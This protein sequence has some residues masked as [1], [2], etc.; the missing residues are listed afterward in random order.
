[1]KKKIG[2]IIF[3]ILIL[4]IIGIEVFVKKSGNDTYF[5]GI[6]TS[7]VDVSKLKTVYVATGGGK[8]AF[9]ADPDVV[10]IMQ[11]KYG[12]NVVYDSWSNGKL[13]VNP[14]VRED[15]SKYDLMFCSDQ[16]FYDYYRLAP[17]K[18]KGEADRYSV[19]KGGL[20]LKRTE[21][22]H[23]IIFQHS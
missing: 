11:S 2:L 19:S 23:F 4:V 5:S 16:R 12:L 9:I 15:G 3:I 7:K 6:P 10:N 17:D 13:I 8:E 21:I 1:M 22:L 14:L 20:I 18:E